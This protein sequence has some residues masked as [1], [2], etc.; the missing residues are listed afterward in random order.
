[1]FK[2]IV[3]MFLSSISSM[4]ILLSADKHEPIGPRNHD[5]I[6]R[7]LFFFNSVILTTSFVFVSMM[8]YREELHY[9]DEL[10]QSLL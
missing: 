6:E 4:K 1:M 7:T 2:L 10:H 5:Q 8:F 3:N 9:I